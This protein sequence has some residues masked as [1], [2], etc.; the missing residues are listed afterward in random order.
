M[1]LTC[2]Y[3]IT[4]KSEVYA[5]SVSKTVPVWTFAFFSTLSQVATLNLLFIG[6]AVNSD[7]YFSQRMLHSSRPDN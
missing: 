1:I 5:K 6:V 3:T 2:C 4:I 7:G